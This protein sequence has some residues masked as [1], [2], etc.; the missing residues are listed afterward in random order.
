MCV[1]GHSANGY[2][3]RSGRGCLE[4]ALE[5]K[6]TVQLCGQRYVASHWALGDLDSIPGSSAKI[7]YIEF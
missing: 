6:T 7:F 4:S 1:P 3:S 5:M 2:F